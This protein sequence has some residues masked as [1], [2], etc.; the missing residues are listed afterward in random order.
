M[1]RFKERWQIVVVGLMV[2]A[3]ADA[4]V[5]AQTVKA[6]ANR[7]EVQ[8]ADPFSFSISVTAQADSKVQFPEVTESI[9][10]FQVLSTRDLFDVPA[11]SGRTWTRTLELE[12]FESGDLQISAQ[13]VFVD[14]KPL[15]AEPVSISVKSIVEPQSDPRNFRELKEVEEIN[16]ESS[17]RWM[18]AGIG[19]GALALAGLAWAVFGRP[20]K[21][22]AASPEQWARSA[23]GEL[24]QSSIYVSKD[25]SKLLPAMANILREYIQRRFGIS[26]PRQTTI[27]FLRAAQDDKRLNDESRDELKRFLEHVDKI[28]FGKLV[29]ETDQIEESFERVQSFID[30]ATPTSQEGGKVA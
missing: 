30:R 3:G 8:V 12:T 9:G 2:I 29:P 28:K 13:T 20:K 27:E 11:K 4:R 1:N 15:Q 17:S 14:G 22:I 18:I 21:R 26:A 19:I 5:S 10:D 6:T 16:I 7:T 24:R 25:Q 23:L